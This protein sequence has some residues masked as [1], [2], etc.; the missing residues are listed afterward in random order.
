ME[1]I[2]Q[3]LRGLL[4]FAHVVEALSFSKAAERLGVTKSAVSKQV[5]QLEAQLGVQLLSRTTRKLSLTDVGERVYT[6]SKE[7]LQTLE[8]AR[9]A[10]HH[11]GATMLGHLRVTA[12]AALGRSFVVPLATAFLTQHPQLSMEIVL[13]D[14]FVDLVMERI[15]VAVRVGRV[16]DSTLVA[17]RLGKVDLVLCASPAYLARHGTPTTPEELTHHEWLQHTP[18]VQEMQLELHKGRRRMSVPVRGRLNCND[19]AGGVRAAVE[20][21]GLVAAPAFE[22]CDEVRSGKLVRLLA[23]WQLPQI[24]IHIVFPPRRHVTSKVRVWADFLG[25][26]LRDPPWR[27]SE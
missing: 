3:D 13:G 24:D 5:A 12:P 18:F 22:L 27:L 15:D 19:G 1:T 6:T 8:A 26:H 2:L 10:A 7:L 16:V 25:E 20:G 11:H 9:E 17:R 14:A 4:V 23:D 21:F